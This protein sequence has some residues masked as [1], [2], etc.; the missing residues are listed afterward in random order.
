VVAPWDGK[1]R[2]VYLEREV[3]SAI[4]LNL[5]GRGPKEEIRNKGIK[6]YNA[7]LKR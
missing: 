4:E 5:Q 6:E 7:A 2:R 3:K 1:N